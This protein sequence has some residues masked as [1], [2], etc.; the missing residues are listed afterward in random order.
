MDASTTPCRIK[1][2]VRRKR[3]VLHNRSSALNQ[4]WKTRSLCAVRSSVFPNKLHNSS[5]FRMV[6]DPIITLSYFL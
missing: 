3:F 2:F 6:F 5:V 4:A 1:A